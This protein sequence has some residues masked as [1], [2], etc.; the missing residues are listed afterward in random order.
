M[1]SETTQVAFVYLPFG[2][3]VF[4]HHGIACL[5]GYLKD[6]GWISRYYDYNLYLSKFRFLYTHVQAKYLKGS[7]LSEM[8]VFILALLIALKKQK[9]LAFSVHELNV[10]TTQKVIRYLNV[11][12]AQKWIIVGGPA[13]MDPGILKLTT[14]D[15]VLFGEG[16]QLFLKTLN[17]IISRSNIKKRRQSSPIVQYPRRLLPLNFQSLPLYEKNELTRY[18]YRDIL[19]VSVNRGC[20]GQCTFCE[21]RL[22]WSKTFRTMTPLAAAKYFKKIISTY[23]YNKYFFTQSILY[24]DPRWMAAFCRKII[25]YNVFWGGCSR[26]DARISQETLSLMF[27]AGCRFLMIGM[28]SGSN[29]M[30]SLMRKSIRVEDTLTFLEKVTAA[31][32]W[33]HGSFIFGFPEQETKEDV[34][35]TIDFIMDNIQLIHSFI[36]SV[37]PS[38]NRSEK[39]EN[40][41]QTITKYNKALNSMIPSIDTL[42]YNA[43]TQTFVRDYRAKQLLALSTLRAVLSKMD[44]T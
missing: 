42:F 41:L 2:D 39:K 38:Q 27:R 16:E 8:S 33:S 20:S 29:R 32:I 3:Y 19:P 34:L 24:D 25:D 14:V 44:Y 26:V 12:A 1:K 5:R 7:F 22:Y 9:I 4:P 30:L 37:Y 13:A 21:E 23:S 10:L 6:K 40:F 36:F 43:H 17:K 31:K 28:E 15:Y 18:A 11:L 35:K